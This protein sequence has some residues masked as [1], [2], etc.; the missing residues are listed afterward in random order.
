[1]AKAKGHLRG[2]QPK[3][4]PRQEA[5]LVELLHSGEY[6]TAELCDLFGVAAP[7]STEP[8][9]AVKRQRA[10]RRATTATASRDATKVVADDGRSQTSDTYRP[11]HG[12]LSELPSEY[13]GRPRPNRT[14]GHPTPNGT[15]SVSNTSTRKV[16][17]DATTCTASGSA[18]GM[19]PRRGPS[20]GGRLVKEV[21][22]TTVRGM[23]A[24]RSAH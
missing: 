16:L 9:P 1:M 17:N 11:R 8:S 14:P 10:G 18:C 20:F 3:L 13:R 21:G 12:A 23:I 7:P 22:G 2:K 4:N 19:A 5:H 24:A 15:L 6:T